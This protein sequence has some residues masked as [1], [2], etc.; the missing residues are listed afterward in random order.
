[1]FGSQD[2]ENVGIEEEKWQKNRI[3]MQVQNK[4]SPSYKSGSKE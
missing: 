3:G 4:F 2:Y 1:M